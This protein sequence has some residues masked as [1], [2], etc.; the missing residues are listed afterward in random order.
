M[1][2][3]EWK[4]PGLAGRALAR[5]LTS[6]KDCEGNGG[7]RKRGECDAEG[8]Q[9]AHL[10]SLLFLSSPACGVTRLETKEQRH[11]QRP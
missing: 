5:F 9:A 7:G 11:L 10:M 6:L 2:C 3:W 8:S 4:G 1:L